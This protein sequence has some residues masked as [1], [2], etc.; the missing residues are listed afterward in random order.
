MH[1]KA[2][3]ESVAVASL[4]T[5]S[6]LNCPGGCT[7]AH[8]QCQW[9]ALRPRLLHL[10]VAG[11]GTVARRG[12]CANQPRPSAQAQRARA[13]PPAGLRRVPRS[14]DDALAG[15]CHAGTFGRS[16]RCE[17]TV[18]FLHCEASGPGGWAT[19]HATSGHSKFTRK[20][21]VR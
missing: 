14:V 1:R 20:L 3:S 5:A 7:V 16:R 21:N 12:R 17:S 4:A 18:S 8:V 19:A 15:L 10:P 13:L 2:P 9:A 11:G 6:K